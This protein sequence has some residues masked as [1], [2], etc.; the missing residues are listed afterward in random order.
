MDIKSLAKSNAKLKVS[1]KGAKKFQDDKFGI[2]IHWGLYSLLKRE[3]WVL[4]KDNIDIYEYEKLAKQFNPIKFSAEEWVKKLVEAGQ[5]SILITAKHHDGFCLYD[6][7]LTGFKVTNSLFGRDPIEELANAC[8]KYSIDLCFYYSLLDWHHP[9]YLNDWED[10]IGYYHDQVRE[11]CTK[12]GKVGY[13]VFDGFW[14]DFPDN[15]SIPAHSHFIPGGDWKLGELYDMIHSLQ[16]DCLI[17]NNM[18]IPPLPG[19]DFQVF[20]LDVPGGNTYGWNTT[21]ISKLPLASWITLSNSW[22]NN[23]DDAAFKPN[24]Q[25]IRTL[26]K[27]TGL[28]AYLMLNIGPDELGQIRQ[29][30]KVRLQYMG[31]WLKKYG[32]AVYGTR[33]VSCI[34]FKFGYVVHKENRIYIYLLYHPGKQIEL[35]NLPFTPK[36][37]GIMGG[38]E[39]ALEVNDETVRISMPSRPYNPMATIIELK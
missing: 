27:S 15:Y 1:E 23:E 5:K 11:L 19:E 34:D 3:E 17:T 25:L 38:E 10:Y 31:Q 29:E 33:P 16:P 18:H 22:S 7:K 36:S 14:P 13:M 12:Y 32:E 21:H 26:L 37:A 24:S 30:E 9:S 8:G 20:E 4:F 2:S 6:S 28:G 39:L 35:N